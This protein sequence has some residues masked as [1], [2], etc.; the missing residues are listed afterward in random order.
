MRLMFYSV[1]SIKKVILINNIHAK[2]IKQ[3]Q[4]ATFASIIFSLYNTSIN[5]FARVLLR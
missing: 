1:S 4:T 5:I 2:L 3:L